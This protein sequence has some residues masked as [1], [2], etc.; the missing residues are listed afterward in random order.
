MPSDKLAFENRW[1]I[2]GK[3]TTRSP[4]VIGNGETTKRTLLFEGLPGGD[5]QLVEI[6]AVATDHRGRAYVPG[7]TIKGCLRSW[8]SRKGVLKDD[9]ERVFGSEDTQQPDESQQ[10]NLRGG[11]AEFWDAPARDDLQLPADPIPY[12]CDTRLTGVA[13]AV[14]I[15]RQRRTA[16]AKKLL[17]YEFVPPGVSFDVSITGQDLSPKDVGLLLFALEG[18]RPDEPDAVT[19]GAEA[20]NGFG[21]CAWELPV[22]TRITPDPGEIQSWLGAG[23][24]G[25]GGLPPVTPEVWAEID[26]AKA[27]I[28][29][30]REPRSV[31]ELGL[32]LRFQGPFL[33]NDPSR[34]NDP[35]RTK[36]KTDP[37]KANDAEPKKPDHAPLLDGKGGPL[38][39][40]RSLRGALR[41]QAERILRTIHPHR[42][43]ACRPTSTREAC[44]SISH[45]S[46]KTSLCLACQVFGAPGWAAPVELSAFTQTT[47]AKLTEFRQEFVAIDRF[48]GGG[49]RHLKF[50]AASF[51]RPVLEGRLVIDLA[52]LGPWALG[53]LVVTLRDLM[54]GD[55]ALGFGQAK[56]YGAVQVD[57]RR[58]SARNV[59]GIAWLV[60]LLAKAGLDK[61]VSDTIIDEPLTQS[62]PEL[63]PLLV[64]LVRALHEKIGEVSRDA[65][66]EGEPV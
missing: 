35:A 42:L 22:V 4:L 32:R 18:V 57:I 24:V 45:K 60:D 2:T 41:S 3:I 37:G 30:G 61:S 36:K 1:R 49:A 13:S 10:P 7:T 5:Q 28:V 20:V 44:K 40:A 16:A 62:P 38:L 43:V 29:A 54:E 63:E 31:L 66:V 34:T 14:A 9:I 33:V 48:T 23:H 50:D 8:L 19:F 52:R 12:W 15:E 55:I 26:K 17:H 39:P 53:L 11:R 6:N 64:Q 56:G 51:Y 25:Y 27:A 21:R 58:F 46:E 47:T 59:A 65:T